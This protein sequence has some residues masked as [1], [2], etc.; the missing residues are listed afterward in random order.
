MA[1]PSIIN[2]PA[3]PA[4]AAAEATA[5]GITSTFALNGR[6]TDSVSLRTMAFNRISAAV[7]YS[8]ANY[9]ANSPRYEPF[10]KASFCGVSFHTKDAVNG[11]STVRPM[12]IKNNVLQGYAA[13]SSFPQWYTG[14]NSQ[15]WTPVNNNASGLSNFNI[16]WILADG[17]ILAGISPSTASYTI[18]RS[19][20]GGAT[21]VDVTGPSG[22]PFTLG[23]A[24][25]GITATLQDASVLQAVNG[26]IIMGEYHIVPGT[27]GYACKVYRSTDSGAT[28]ALVFALPTPIPAPTTNY[29]W[30]T[31]AKQE[32]LGVWIGINGDGSLNRGIWNSL[33][34]GLTWN[35]SAAAGSFYFQP[36]GLLDFGDPTRLLVGSDT[37]METSLL[38]INSAG[39]VL[40]ITQGWDGDPS[41]PYYWPL[42]YFR[43]VFYSI[44][45]DYVTADG[46][47]HC[48]LVCSTDLVNW[49]AVSEVSIDGSAYS[50][51]II[52]VV[53][54]ELHAQAV[55]ATAAAGHI[56]FPLP[57]VTTTQSVKV[58]PPASNLLTGD[59]STDFETGIG[60]LVK[61]SGSP[62]IVQSSTNGAWHGTYYAQ[63]TYADNSW[64]MDQA[65]ATVSTAS[66]TAITG[67]VYYAQVHM[68]SPLPGQRVQLQFFSNG[69]GTTVGTALQYCLDNT[70]RTFDAI[71]YTAVS[72]D[73]AGNLNLQITIYNEAS[74]GNV[75]V[76]LDGVMLST[77]SGAWTPAGF[78]AARSPE[79]LSQALRTTTSWTHG[80]TIEPSSQSD[81]LITTH[82]LVLSGATNSSPI[83]C[84][85]T[86]A[87][88]LADGQRVT[89]AGG[90]ANTAVNGNWYTK[91]T[92]NSATTFQLYQ[93]ANLTLNV[94]GN[95]TYTASSASISASSLYGI[96]TYQ[97]DPLNYL[98]VYF[99]ASD[100]T[101]AMRRTIAGVAQTAVKTTAQYFTKKTRINITVC[102]DVNGITLIV[103]NE[104]DPIQITDTAFLALNNALITWRNGTVTQT[105]QLPMRVADLVLSHRPTSAA[106]LANT[107]APVLS[108][109]QAAVASTFTVLSNGGSYVG[110]TYSATGTQTITLPATPFVGETHQI[111]DEGGSAGS[112]NITVAGNG[113]NINGAAN[114]LISANFGS[115]TIRYN[116]TQWIKVA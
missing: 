104:T 55:L 39:T 26:T 89:I 29:H 8:G 67:Q 2:P 58:D 105:S 95:G 75:E 30:H 15:P 107:L 82:A 100:Q 99:D 43:G 65:V 34:D 11:T 10:V 20:D 81:K 45:T 36:V 80:F 25:N 22:S 23:V 51:R 1:V 112:N 77:S 78:A 41:H 21:F 110:S 27:Q 86:S 33:D 62:T 24:A 102:S 96:A 70:W 85:A 87:H 76:H 19:I 3:G 6:L 5:L 72:G 53:N 42:G 92:G 115:F 101:F 68:R 13:N 28:W 113:K 46:S 63:I 116:G 106:S 94:A 44:G 16:A 59:N 52:G 90:L 88:G 91:V 38:T 71:P 79:I 84:T 69:Q 60:G 97:I 14:P 50:K 57:T 37:I 83:F 111:T 108:N 9:T 93:D 56:S 114:M 17:T 40:A 35:R 32:A 7:S 18:K 98:E 109:Y 54:N 66:I 103:G 12:G 4:I 61:T 47:R 74:P 48:P 31:F 73:N 49:A 64:T